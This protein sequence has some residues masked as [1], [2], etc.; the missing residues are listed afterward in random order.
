MASLFDISLLSHFSDVFVILFV[1][2]A[3]YAILMVQKPFGDVKGLNALMA[4][5]VAMMLVFSQNAI[6]IVKETVPWFIIIIVALM[7]VLLTTKS[8]GA[9]IPIP[10]MNNI[11]TYILV[12][13]S[14]I[15]L[16]NISLS[17]GQNIGPFL[18]NE[19][20]DSNNVQP[21]GGGEVGS[22]N[23]A[24]NLG[25]TLFH[26]KVLAMILVLV[27]SLFAVLLIGYWI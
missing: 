24:Q 20:T 8:I 1:F 15:L 2:T 9:D 11:G 7:F 14:I 4:F 3:V 18:G 17:L 27:V 26:P 25:A 13:G 21:G 16:I 12:I 19:T 23:F 22:G 5:A 10:L 6:N